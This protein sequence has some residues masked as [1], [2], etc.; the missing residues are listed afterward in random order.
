MWHFFL[1][2]LN[3]CLPHGLHGKQYCLV[4]ICFEKWFAALNYLYFHASV[5][6][7]PWSVWIVNSDWLGG[8]HYKLFNA[9]VV[10]VSLNAIYINALLVTHKHTHVSY[11]SR[12]EIALRIHRNI[13]G[14]RNASSHWL[15]LKKSLH[16]ISQQ[17]QGNITVYLCIWFTACRMLDLLRRSWQK[18]HFYSSSHILLCKHQ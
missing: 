5:I 2:V 13:Q 10:P 9:Q 11:I 1:L 7:A 14:H 4:I 12:S 6:H 17:Q 16:Y 8:V 3:G 18:R 15:L